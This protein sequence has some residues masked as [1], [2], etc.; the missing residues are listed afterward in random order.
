MRSREKMAGTKL[1]EVRWRPEDPD[2]ADE[3]GRLCKEA[4]ARY[5]DGTDALVVVTVACMLVAQRHR[6]ATH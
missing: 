2:T 4:T 1:A 5:E 3:L 6:K